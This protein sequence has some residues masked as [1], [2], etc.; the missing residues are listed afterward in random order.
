VY[1][2]W[3]VGEEYTVRTEGSWRIALPLQYF[4]KLSNKNFV[5]FEQNASRKMFKKIVEVIAQNCLNS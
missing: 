1:V 4:S 5:D 3:A 2:Q